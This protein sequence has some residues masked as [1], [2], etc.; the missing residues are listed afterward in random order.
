MSQKLAEIQMIRQE[1]I[2][3]LL[4]QLEEDAEDSI[5]SHLQSQQ[6]EH[7]EQEQH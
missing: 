5:K 2:K 4:K 3:N 6:E 1:N 7:F